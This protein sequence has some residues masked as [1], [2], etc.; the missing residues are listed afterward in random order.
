M[1]G[2]ILA[3]A[4]IAP[5]SKVLEI[6]CGTANLALRAKLAHP[7]A[8]VVACDSDPQVLV[9]A[10]RRATGLSGF[11]LVKCFAQQLPYADSE[12]DRALAAMMFR[13][14]P[15]DEKRAVAI[16]ILR[17]LK[18]SGHLHLVDYRDGSSPHH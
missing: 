15:P 8:D 14:L 4:G 7:Q 5:D 18:P 11:R 12:F 2:A 3:Q 6:G 9:R 1:H 10:Q 13:Q 16:E 17:V